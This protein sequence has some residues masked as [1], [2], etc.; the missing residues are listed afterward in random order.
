MRKKDVNE[1]TDDLRFWNVVYSDLISQNKLEKHIKNYPSKRRYREVYPENESDLKVYE[2][3]SP[4][5]LMFAKVV[6]EHY[7]LDIN[8]KSEFTVEGRISCAVIHIPKAIMNTLYNND[9][10]D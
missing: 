3:D 7:D 9:Y 8:I 5:G 6:A 2:T 4:D 10:E 1:V